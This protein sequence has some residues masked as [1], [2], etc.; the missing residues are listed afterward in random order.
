MRHLYIKEI[1]II[2]KKIKMPR[3]WDDNHGMKCTQQIPPNLI[4]CLSSSK[5]QGHFPKFIDQKKERRYVSLMRRKF[6]DARLRD[7]T[8]IQHGEDFDI[9]F[10][11][12]IG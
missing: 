2:L 12:I 9:S 4:F 10:F 1:I 6:C 3:K 8:F 5:E 7:L 11:N